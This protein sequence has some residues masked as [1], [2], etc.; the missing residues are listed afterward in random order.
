MILT[1]FMMCTL[2][3]YCGYYLATW[4]HHL[5]QQEQERQCDVASYRRRMQVP[6]QLPRNW[7]EG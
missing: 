6:V 5:D 2:S 1:V 7:G 3:F 4:L